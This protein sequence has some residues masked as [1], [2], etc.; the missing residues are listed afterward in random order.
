MATCSLTQGF[1]LSGCKDGVGGLVAA[2]IIERGNVTSYVK[3]SGQIS[4]I[5]KATGKQ[6]FKYELQRNTSEYKEEIEGNPDNG[7]VAYKQSLSLVLNRLDLTT[8]NEI[9]LLVRNNV[10]V[11]VQDRMGLYWLLGEQL[12]C[13]VVK[14]SAGAGKTGTDRRGFT[15]ELMAEEPEMAVS[16]SASVAAA[17]TTPG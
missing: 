2:Y 15:L 10:W 4:S 8:R 7:T 13:D 17:L 6:F 16:I 12:G 9:L 14:G 11:V 1:T 3:S 5:T